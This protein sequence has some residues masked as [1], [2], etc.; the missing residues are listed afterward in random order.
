MISTVLQSVI[1]PTDPV[2]QE[3]VQ[4]I[5]NDVIKENPDI[6]NMNTI[7]GKDYTDA[8]EKLEGVNFPVNLIK[9]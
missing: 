1:T 2:V 7:N 6:Q 9:S 5:N 4:Q 3:K 8:F